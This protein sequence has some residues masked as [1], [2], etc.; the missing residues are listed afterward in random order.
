MEPLTRDQINNEL[1]Q[2]E[3]WSFESDKI[4][5]ELKFS[6]FRQAIS[7]MVRVGFEAEDMA[8]HPEWSNVYNSVSISLSTHDA[9]GKVTEKDIK[10]ASAIDKIY[11]EN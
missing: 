9:G 7:F 11:K 2:L 10:L 1:K 3:D 6:N 8:H 4:H 5:R